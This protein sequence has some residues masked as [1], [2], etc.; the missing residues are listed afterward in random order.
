MGRSRLLTILPTV[1]VACATAT[2]A[3]SRDDPARAGEVLGQV[4]AWLDATHDLQGGFEQRV[5][6]GALGSG[7]AESG[8]L[9]IER[10]GRMR[11][12]YLAPE[13]KVALVR[14]ELTWF[15]LEEDEQLIRGRLEPGTDLLPQLLAGSKRLDELFDA[16]LEPSETEGSLRLR[17]VPRSGSDDFERVTLTVGAGDHAIRGAEVL[18]AAGNEIHYRFI[19]LRR[20]AGLPADTFRFEA[21]PGTFVSGQ[22]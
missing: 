14:D 19:D 6:S 21:P 5:V 13:R 18:D 10:P 4:Q 9:W 2:A 20:N 15:Y 11:W 7:M 12:D 16:S 22:H 17:L 1:A 8:K 3:T